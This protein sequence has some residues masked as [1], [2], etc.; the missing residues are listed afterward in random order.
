[1][2]PSWTRLT[3]DDRYGTIAIALHWLLAAGLL[4]QIA[5]GWYLGEVPRNT[6]ARTVW[7]NFH[8]S[9]GVTLGVLIVFRLA[10]RLTHAP[11]SFPVSMPR[12]E[13]VAASVNH[14]LL[15][16]CMVGMP[17]TGYLA[18]N[19][20]RFGIKYFGLVELQPWGID[21]KVIYALFNST[22]KALALVFVSLIAL[23]V[24]A[25]VKHALIDR[26]GVMRR[27]LPARNRIKSARGHLKES[28]DKRFSA[29]DTASS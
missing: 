3:V 10:W 24:A 1:M 29:D 18:T 20:S 27:M 2:A 26:D 28:A 4:F 19:F 11:P 9:V 15:Y 7:V 25:A 22:H 16:V 13:R 23:H 14:A 6:P 5:L 21:D 12:W 8:K 17:L